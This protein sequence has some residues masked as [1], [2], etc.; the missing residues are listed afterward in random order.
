MIYI[1]SGVAVANAVVTSSPLAVAG[2]ATP[3]GHPMAAMRGAIPASKRRAAA[4]TV[5]SVNRGT[6]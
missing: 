1:N 2:P 6:T 3:A 5:A 4:A